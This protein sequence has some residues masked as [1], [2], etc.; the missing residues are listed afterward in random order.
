MKNARRIVLALS[1]AAALSLAACSSPSPQPA[2]TSGA[3]G[4]QS[5][6]PAQDAVAFKKY[7]EAELTA[8]LKSAKGSDGKPLTVMPSA[9]FKQGLEMMKAVAS[10]L[11]VTPAECAPDSMTGGLSA[12]EGA[13]TA[14]A[15]STA[16]PEQA[17]VE[18]VSLVSGLSEDVLSKDFAAVKEQAEKC[19]D[20]S[21]DL[22]GQKVEA[23]MELMPVSASTPGALA[24]KST[25]KSAAG[26]SVQII[27]TAVKGG[28]SISSSYT[29]AGDVDAELKKAA[30][31]LDSVAALIK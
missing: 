11:K 6:A 5:Q 9:Q 17:P 27:V 29:S 25:S 10:K 8:L 1:T 21:I 2:G 4:A 30:A 13:T 16:T 15:S 12:L 3:P 26:T 24:L 22:A 19:K 20:I 31:T 7:S 14:V 18:T 23:S 28:L